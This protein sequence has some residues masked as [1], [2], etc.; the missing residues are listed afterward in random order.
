MIGVALVHVGLVT[1]ETRVYATDASA[2]RRFAR[3]WR[4]IYPGSALIRR[5]WLRAMKR[6]AE[7]AG[8]EKAERRPL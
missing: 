3:Y 4:V 5:R 8:S 1:A 7:A 2:R 6:R